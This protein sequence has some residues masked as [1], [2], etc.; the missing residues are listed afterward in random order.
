MNG[1]LNPIS[2]I[3]FTVNTGAEFDSFIYMEIQTSFTVFLFITN[4]CIEGHSTAVNM[5][6]DP[7]S[8]QGLWGLS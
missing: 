4:I 8:A 3:S 5:Q 1:T 2:F 7:H 6:S